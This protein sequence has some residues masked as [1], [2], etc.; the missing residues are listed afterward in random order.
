M[1]AGRE[2][3]RAA[4]G[5]YTIVWLVREYQIDDNRY[6]NGGMLLL[7]TVKRVLGG[8]SFQA[9]LV[10]YCFSASA[11]YALGAVYALEQV[12]DCV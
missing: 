3:R 6:V 5:S 4:R 2:G 1:L 10:V 11:M 12:D 7:W 8:I 9:S